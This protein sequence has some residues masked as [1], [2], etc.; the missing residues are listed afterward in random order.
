M[1]DRQHCRNTLNQLIQSK[2]KGL[3]LLVVSI[4]LSFVTGY[5]MTITIIDDIN[6]N[7]LSK[8]KNKIL[9]G[10]K[11]TAFYNIFVLRLA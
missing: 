1:S 5:M 8:N 2:S 6:T 11:I 7:I 9:Q 10:R 4:I 3:N